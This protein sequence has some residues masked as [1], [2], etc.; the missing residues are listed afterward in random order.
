MNK[1][2]ALFLLGSLLPFFG[3]SQKQGNIIEW[4]AARPLELSDFT[5]I[6]DQSAKIADS[7]LAVTRTGITYT[8][9]QK[10]GA[11]T[12]EIRLFATMHRNNSFIRQRVLDA[13]GGSIDYLLSHEQRHFDISEIFAREAVKRITAKRF[14]KNY[15]KEV[16]T[17]MRSLFRESESLQN[18]YDRETRNGRDAVAQKLWDEKIDHQLRGLD[19]YKKK[20][21]QKKIR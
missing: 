4:S 16:N 18:L 15:A 20:V 11:N 19:M 14:T 3:F 9:N 6:T 2:I 12:F 13:P 1:I 17:I 21:L 7:N 10:S 5:V 8:I